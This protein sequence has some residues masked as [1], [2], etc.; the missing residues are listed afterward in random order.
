[1]EEPVEHG[2]DLRGDAL[3]AAAVWSMPGP[4][5]G[6]PPEES[7]TATVLGLAIAAAAA[8]WNAPASSQAPAGADDDAP[9]G[10]AWMAAD[11]AAAGD[12]EPLHELGQDPLD[13]LAL[14]D[15]TAVQLPL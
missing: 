5:E 9:G 13:V 7:G 12:E 11:P 14:P 1:V 10:L 4:S 2:A 8:W 3:A 6:K 15:L